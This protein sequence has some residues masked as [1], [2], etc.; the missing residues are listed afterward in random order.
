[1]LDKVISMEEKDERKKYRELVR[2]RLPDKRK[3][4]SCAELLWRLFRS[5]AVDPEHAVSTTKISGGIKGAHGHLSDLRKAKLVA[6]TSKKPIRAF[7]NG[8]NPGRPFIHGREIPIARDRNISEMKRLI[9]DKASAKRVA[10]AS[11]SAVDEEDFSD[12]VS[13]S[14]DVFNMA[15]DALGAA[16]LLDKAY[17]FG[18][19]G[20][21]TGSDSWYLLE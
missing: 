3:K 9:T 6:V 13:A 19:M 14:D 8:G 11:V 5:G 4:E 17:K 10:F 18:K 12:K 20:W 2:A 21:R 1:M 7:L 15:V 16:N